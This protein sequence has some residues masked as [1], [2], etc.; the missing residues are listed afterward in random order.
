MLAYPWQWF[1]VRLLSR[2]AQLPKCL[3]T[4]IT[5]SSRW[6]LWF[7]WTVLSTTSLCR[8]RIVVWPVWR[9]E[10]GTLNRYLA[11]PST[12]V[13]HLCLF[14]QTWSSRT[15]LLF[16]PLSLSLSLSLSLQIFAWPDHRDLRRVNLVL[17]KHSGDST[18][19]K[20]QPQFHSLWTAEVTMPDQWLFICLV[21][22]TS[23]PWGRPTH[24][25]VA[26]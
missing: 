15:C 19:R 7:Y 25:G 4:T 13:R 9:M 1:L 16:K 11:S 20:S 2:K 5:G 3:I 12:K 10:R 21:A 18:T 22:P 23:L 17:R 14:C 6:R 26:G 8:V 24:F